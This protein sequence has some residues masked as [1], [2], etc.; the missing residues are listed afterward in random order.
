MVSSAFAIG[1]LIVPFVVDVSRSYLQLCAAVLAV[2]GVVGIL[3]FLFHAASV[4]R[5]P[6]ATWFEKILSGAP[7]MAPLLLPN[8]VVLATIAL[9]VLDRWMLASSAE[10]RA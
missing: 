3:G 5:Q 6:A 4:A 1:F 10:R 2:Q 7:P 8:L 9:W